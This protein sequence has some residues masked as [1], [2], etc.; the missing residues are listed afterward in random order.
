MKPLSL[1][2]RP[3]YAGKSPEF[4]ELTVHPYWGMNLS[5]VRAIF[6]GLGEIDVLALPSLEAAQLSLNVETEAIAPFQWG[7]AILLPFANRIRGRQLG[8]YIE[9]TIVGRPVSLPANWSGKR[10]GAERCAMHGLILQSK[11]AEIAMTDDRIAATYEAGNFGGH[12]PSSTRV[13]VETRLQAHRITLEVTAQ[14][15]GQE[16]LPI[17]IGWHPY[18]ALP[19]QKRQEARLRLPAR[20]RVFVNNYDDVFPTGQLALVAGTDYDF[21]GSKGNQLGSRH[22]DD[23]FVDLER[24]SEG[25]LIIEI[26]DPSVGYGLRIASFSQE[27][28]AVQ[29]YAPIGKAF[30]AVEP[31]FNW[32]DPFSLIWPPDTDTG[33][34]LLT[35]GEHVTWGMSCELFV[36]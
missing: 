17:G 6:P 23:C 25:L 29:V 24:N 31:Q 33:M 11:I 28:K 14:N 21:C 20:Q 9:T 1:H 30:V 7:G 8:N 36:I 22:F 16:V 13:R 34:V 15:T 12:W 3:S 18:F 35:P 4:L 27:V 2:R 19:G 26:I 32:A 5:Q 10:P